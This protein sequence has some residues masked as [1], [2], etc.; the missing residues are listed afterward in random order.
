MTEI[1]D[2]SQM[3]GVIPS[4]ELN[5]LANQGCYNQ[6]IVSTPPVLP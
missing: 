1:F 4:P 3:S 5:A 2:L 6:P